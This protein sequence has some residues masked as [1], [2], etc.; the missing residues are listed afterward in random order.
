MLGDSSDLVHLLVGGLFKHL[1]EQLVKWPMGYERTSETLR[2]ST[3]KKGR[4]RHTWVL[5]SDHVGH[6]IRTYRLLNKEFCTEVDRWILEWMSLVKSH[7]RDAEAGGEYGEVLITLLKTQLSYCF[8]QEIVEGLCKQVVE[9]AMP[10]LRLKE[11]VTTFMCMCTQRCQIHATNPIESAIANSA[12]E[13]PC[14]GD[15]ICLDSQNF[16]QN[17]ALATSDTLIYACKK[18][19]QCAQM[20]VHI[21]FLSN[22][23]DTSMKT[24][25]A[26]AMFRMARM[27]PLVDPFSHV[28][29]C[30]ATR[31]WGRVDNRGNFVN[32]D[33]E[34][35]DHALSPAIINSEYDTYV[36]DSIHWPRNVMLLRNISLHQDHDSIQQMLGLSDAMVQTAYSD[37]LRKMNQFVQRHLCIANHRNKELVEDIGASIAHMFPNASFPFLSLEEMAEYYPGMVASL[38]VAVSTEVETYKHGITSGGSCRIREHAMD[39]EQVRRAMFTISQFFRVCKLGLECSLGVCS[40]YDY[41]SGMHV[42]LYGKLSLSWAPGHGDMTLP[43]GIRDAAQNPGASPTFIS[44]M[45]TA[46]D[47]FTGLNDHSLNFRNFPYSFELST[48][49]T[50]MTMFTTNLFVALNEPKFTTMYTDI[51]TLVDNVCKDVWLPPQISFRYYKQQVSAPDDK[52]KVCQGETLLH[53]DSDYRR[54]AHDW[55]CEMFKELVRHPG[56]RCAA[57]DLLGIGP[58]DILHGCNVEGTYCK[59]RT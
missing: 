57:L 55:Y 43:E 30:H 23:G 1:R 14:T 41:F 17:I 40:A 53:P 24:N 48:S 13:W 16:C 45:R 2:R 4:K 46:V 58:A 12:K 27:H 36:V 18:C 21:R 54:S 44:G 25:L 31:C 42:G 39:I 3:T 33:N 34:E 51:R 59:F 38:R 29:I 5:P 11:D 50:Q 52:R 56:T 15:N 32:I 49:H 35:M 47:F 22:S 8:P 19:L 28:G 37:V 26:R 9:G 10:V 7:M 6:I 20:N